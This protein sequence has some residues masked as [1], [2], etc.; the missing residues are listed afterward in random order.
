MDDKVTF[1]TS[2]DAIPGEFWKLVQGVTVIDP[3]LL[4]G[5]LDSI[6]VTLERREAPEPEALED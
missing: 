3:G 4:F 5:P 6:R 2:R 1:V